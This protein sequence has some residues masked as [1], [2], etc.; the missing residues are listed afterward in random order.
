MALFRRI[1]AGL[2]FCLLLTS[3]ASEEHP[4]SV[5][6]VIDSAGVII[7]TTHGDIADMSPIGVL[8]AEPAIVIGILDGDPASMFG[9]IWSVRRVS[10]RL[11]AVADNQA[12]EVRFFDEGG[13]HIRTV[14]GRGGGPGEFFGINTVS[15]AGEDTVCVWDTRAQR[16]SLFTAAEGLIRTFLLPGNAPRA[17]S[18][19]LLPDGHL[20]VRS[21]WNPLSYSSPEVPSEL[22]LRRDSAVLTV[23]DPG[24]SHPD[25]LLVLPLMESAQGMLDGMLTLQ[26]LPFARRGR[27]AV[28]GGEVVS[29]FNDVFELTWYDLDEEPRMITRFPIYSRPLNE[30]TIIALRDQRLGESGVTQDQAAMIRRSFD[31]FP[32]P[33]TQPAFGKILPGVPQG[34]W[35]QEDPLWSDDE[36]IPWWFLDQSSGEVT[37]YL[38]IPR[39]LD[40]FEIGPDFVLGS[41][42]SEIGVPRVELYRWSPFQA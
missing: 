33:E 23:W 34:V 24:G 40:V 36:E 31:E 4:S 21:T 8:S 32:H 27:Y 14:G 5:V 19:Q 38:R 41:T 30:E 18:V 15:V 11:I 42:E 25:T 2:L 1:V 17:F 16:M 28:V 12:L 26:T 29:G 3:C 37:G 35:V 6:E 10:N 22:T 7:V 39:G 9:S 13:T 20:L